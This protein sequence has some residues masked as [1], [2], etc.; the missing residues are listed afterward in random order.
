MNL[1]IKAILSGSKQTDYFSTVTNMLHFE[2]IP[3]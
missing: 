3:I 2:G 1:K